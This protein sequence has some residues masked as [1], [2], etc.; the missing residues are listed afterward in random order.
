MTKMAKLFLLFIILFSSPL[1]HGA[2]NV[3]LM[4]GDGMGVTH[5]TATRI[6]AKKAWGN[7]HID[8]MPYTAKV[9]TYAHDD[10]VTDSASAI[11]SYAAGKKVNNGTLGMDENAIFRKKDGRSLVNIAD[12]AKKQGKSVGVV[13]T[14]RVTHATP[15]GFYAH[16]NDRDNEA[17]IAEQLLSSGL[18]VAF[19]GGQKF[20]QKE[21]RKDGKDLIQAFKA[22]GVQV[23]TTRSELRHLNNLKLGTPVLG[24]FSDNHMTYMVE[25]KGDQEPLLS[26]MVR[27]AI[28]HLSKNPNGYFLMVEGGRIDHAAHDNLAKH[29]FEETLA[30]DE[31]VAQA[32]TQVNLA[33]TLV[34]VTADHATG[35]LNINMGASHDKSIFSE[36]VDEAYPPNV[37]VP[38]LSWATGPNGNADRKP[39]TPLTGS[40]PYESWQPAQFAAGWAGHTGED[41][42][43]YAQG[44]GAEKIHG[45]IENTEVF[46][47]MKNS[48]GF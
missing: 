44:V 5:V 11:T 40:R 43:L 38:V 27:F 34:L 31:S 42:T 29:M 39:A 6:Y 17:K 14:T 15:A 33:D 41:V 22:K 20:F 7:L 32:L 48:F 21:K 16:V 10:I 28:D 45:T 37:H 4:I 36:A 46:N 8:Q 18:D 19:G 2:K 1:A 24:L 23:V 13:T 9:K 35:G 3:I 47:I 12:L 25:R 26:E 30:F